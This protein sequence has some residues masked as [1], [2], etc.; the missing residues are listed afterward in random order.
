MAK[1][2]I[3]SDLLERAKEHAEA[4]G[5]HSVEDLVTHLLEQEM[6]SSEKEPEKKEDVEKRLKGLGY[7]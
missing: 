3:D 4:T 2:K 7:M 6:N 1:L 5:Y